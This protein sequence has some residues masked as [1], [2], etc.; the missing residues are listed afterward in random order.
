[1]SVENSQFRNENQH[2][3]ESDQPTGRNFFL[4]TPVIGRQQGVGVKVNKAKRKVN[5]ERESF[6]NSL[7][8]QEKRL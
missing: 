3:S 4:L 2:H 8:L 6:L 5:G 1:M 7:N